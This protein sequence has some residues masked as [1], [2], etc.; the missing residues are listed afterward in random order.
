[1]LEALIPSRRSARC[2]TSALLLAA[3]ALLASCASQKPP[4]ALVDDP[5]ANHDSS[6]PW[7][8]P[9]SWEGR[10]NVPAGLGE[11]NNPGRPAGY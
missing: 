3:F 6:I 9:Q 2:L 7:N 8:K 4:I 5:S 1:M 11:S 10:G